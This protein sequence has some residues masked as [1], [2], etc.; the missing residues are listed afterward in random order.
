[1]PFEFFISRRY[2]KSRQKQAFIS[3]ITLLSIAGVTIGVMALIIVIG[4]MSGF[5]SDMKTRML[6]V[7]PHAVLMRDGGNFTDYKNISDQLNS[8]EDI[9]GATPVITSQVMLRSPS[10]LLSGAVLWGIDP[11]LAGKVFPVLRSEDLLNLEKKDQAPAETAASST[12]AVPA[13]RVPGLILGKQLARTLGVVKNDVVYM[14]SPK[15][16]V[17]PVGH[18]PAMKKFK[19]VGIFES[20]IYDYDG[21][22]AY[23]HLK[24]AQSLLGKGDTVTGI[25]IKVKDVFKARDTIDPIALKLGY[26]YWAQDWTQMNQTL[27]SALKLEKWAM[28]IML[29]LIIVVAAL[30]IASALIMLVMEKTK[31]IAILK[32]MGATSRHIRRIFVFQGIMIGTMGTLL[33]EVFGYGACLLLKRYEFIKLPPDVYY[34]STLPVRIE[35]TD[36]LIIAVASMMICFFATLYPSHQASKMN[37]V[38]AFRYG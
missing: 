31:D 14:I 3:L 20:G 9:T 26:P 21:S 37:P 30:N 11:K 6:G 7:M 23:I 19:I 10:G 2:L 38:E 36:T 4:V 24:D 1:M 33:G 15:M 34:I 18:I 12:E 25:Y 22:Y 17:S 13:Y 32:A 29:T 27:F 5:A 16:I 8:I 28:F 35:F